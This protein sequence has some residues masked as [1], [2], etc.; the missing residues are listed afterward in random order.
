LAACDTVAPTGLRPPHYGPWYSTGASMNFTPLTPTN[1]PLSEIK[2][3]R[4]NTT[5][6]SL[7][8]KDPEV[9]GAIPSLCNQTVRTYSNWSF[10]AIRALG[11]PPTNMVPVD[12]S[13]SSKTFWNSRDPGAPGGFASRTGFRLHFKRQGADLSTYDTV[14]YDGDGSTC[15]STDVVSFKFS[16][17]ISDFEGV[18][19]VTIELRPDAFYPPS[20]GC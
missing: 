12:V 7:L 10:T 20:M 13:F 16:M 3:F 15:G 5:T 14:T 19:E 18:D 9:C 8:M 17:T 4:D 1:S 11:G 6:R 2:D